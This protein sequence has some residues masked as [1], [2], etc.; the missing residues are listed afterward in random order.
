MNLLR[1]FWGI[2]ISWEKGNTEENKSINNKKVVRLTVKH[3]Q[4]EENN[5]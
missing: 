3:Y 5:E 4:K 2:L 1:T